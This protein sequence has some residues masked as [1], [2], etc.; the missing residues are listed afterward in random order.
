MGPVVRLKWKPNGPFGPE[1]NEKRSF[2]FSHSFFSS[3]GLFSF[4]LFVV[5]SSLYISSLHFTSPC[6]L[7]L[8]FLYTPQLISVTHP[9]PTRHR[10]QSDSLSSALTNGITLILQS[11]VQFTVYTLHLTIYNLLSFYT[12]GTE[13]P[14]P[15]MSLPP[16]NTLRTLPCPSCPA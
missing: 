16:L 2:V 7:L 15:R 12:C 6:L 14:S 11:V 10:N 8:I 3:S 13:A 9:S 4:T 1:N 5:Y